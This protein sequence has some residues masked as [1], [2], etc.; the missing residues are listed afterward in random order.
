MSTVIQISEAASIAL[1]STVLI[2]RAGGTNVTVKDIVSATG[3]SHAH[4]SK[5]LQQLV[6]AGLVCSTRGPKGG[7][8]LSRPAAG[9]TLL[10]V[11]EAV[12]GPLRVDTCIVSGNP[13]ECPFDSCILGELPRRLSEE[14]RGYLG[15]RTLASVVEDIAGDTRP[16]REAGG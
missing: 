11:W 15:S 6:R 7:F 1:H 9:I 10:G 8:L 3:F 2:A 14:F 16:S 5:V 13:D 4:S 12:E